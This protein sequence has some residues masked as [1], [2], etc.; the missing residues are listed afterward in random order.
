MNFFKKKTS[1]NEDAK[2]EAQKCIICNEHECKNPICESCMSKVLRSARIPVEFKILLDRMNYEYDQS[3]YKYILVDIADL[4]HGMEKV[5]N[6]IDEYDDME[7]QYDKAIA[8]LN[9][10]RSKFSVYKEN[11]EEELSEM[12]AELKKKNKI[13]QTMKTIKKSIHDFFDV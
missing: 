12:R 7:K 13:K 5:C 1:T 2:T 4:Y 11:A 8:V 9:E 6:M 10:T 3:H